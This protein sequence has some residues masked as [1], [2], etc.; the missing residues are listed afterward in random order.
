M[1]LMH[2]LLLRLACWCAAVAVGSTGTDAGRGL[3]VKFSRY[4]P[5]SA[6]ELTL[7]ACVRAANGSHRVIERRNPAARLPTDFLL[8]EFPPA[9]LDRVAGVL[10]VRICQ[11]SVLRSVAGASPNLAFVS[12]GTG[13]PRSGR[14]AYSAAVH[15]PHDALRGFGA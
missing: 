7:A 2:R 12:F 1:L 8:V 6:H 4:A 3:I 9:D 15:T 10:R 11:P 13:A 5:A 14:R